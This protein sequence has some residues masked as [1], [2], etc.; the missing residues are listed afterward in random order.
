MG[1]E[2]CAVSAKSVDREKKGKGLA[3]TRAPSLQ[4]V[5]VYSDP[6]LLTAP[7]VELLDNNDS[8]SKIS[9]A[10]E[11]QKRFISFE[12]NTTLYITGTR[13]H[14]A[15]HKILSHRLYETEPFQ[16]HQRSFT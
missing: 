12:K 5:R 13:M 16:L 1:N 3:F 14:I 10:A 15:T 7:Y 4:K 2:P 11:V 6:S 8:K 9:T